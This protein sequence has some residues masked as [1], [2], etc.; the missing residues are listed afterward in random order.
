V[1]IWNFLK[2]WGLG[3]YLP[4]GKYP[5]I[6]KT[7]IKGFIVLK[8]LSKVGFYLLKSPLFAQIRR[9]LGFYFVLLWVG[10]G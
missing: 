1:F 10:F 6:L 3:V 7:F 8:K 4:L 9:N 2:K 5:L